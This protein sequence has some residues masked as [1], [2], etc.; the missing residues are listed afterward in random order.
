MA[1]VFTV[2]AQDHREVQAMLAE[3]EKGPT[4]ATG[5]SADQLAL[6]K[7]MAETLIIEESKHEALE[8]MYFWPAVREHHRP[9]TRSPMRQPARSRKPSMCSPTWT[10]S[11]PATA[12]SRNCSARSPER[13]GST[14]R[15][16][17]LR[18]GR[19]C[20]QRCQR[21]WPTSWAPRSPKARRPRPRVP[22]RIPPPRP[23]CSRPPGLR[24]PPP[25]RHVT[26]RPAA[27]PTDRARRSRGHPDDD[28]G[29]ARHELA[30]IWRMPARRPRPVLPDLIS[31]PGAQPDCPGQRRSAPAAP[32]SVECPE[33][34]YANTPIQGIWG[35]TTAEEQQNARHREQPAIC[36]VVGSVEAG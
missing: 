25:T 2:L 26:R 15:S 7:K 18:C 36:G 9:A 21:R 31:R 10:S 29:R 1:D 32:S 24:W 17:R 33:F 3:L 34:A 12:G 19:A 4:G 8:E 27:G 35:G 14:S 28:H 6:R 30:R 20:A 22:I 5:A 13:P 16:R 11:M 23:P